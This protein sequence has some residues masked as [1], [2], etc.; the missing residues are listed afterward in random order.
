MLCS[1]DVSPQV[2]ALLILSHCLRIT[3]CF[4]CHACILH[5]NRHHEGVEKDKSRDAMSVSME[6]VYAAT[7][8]SVSAQTFLL[9]GETF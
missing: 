2:G 1:S 5:T 8:A 3:E 9:K 4:L 6:T 7:S